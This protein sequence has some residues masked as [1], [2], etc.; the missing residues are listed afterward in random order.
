MALGQFLDPQEKYILSLLIQIDKLKENQAQLIAMDKAKTDRLNQL[1]GVVKEK[2]QEIVELQE[3]LNTITANAEPVSVEVDPHVLMGE[4]APVENESQYRDL[5]K[6]EPTVQQMIEDPNAE[7]LVEVPTVEQIQQSLPKAEEESL[8]EPPSDPVQESSFVMPEQQVEI[9]S[10]GI[11]STQSPPDD[12][13]C[14][15]VPTQN[16][17]TASFGPPPGLF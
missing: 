7:L 12:S 1:D 2:L 9:P 16:I 15:N 8:P 11:I 10:Q 17:D 4:P 14:K 5:T 13:M 3:H 6:E